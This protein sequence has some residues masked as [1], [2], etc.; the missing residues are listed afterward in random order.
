MRRVRVH[1]DEDEDEDE[2]QD[3]D[4]D[5]DREASPDLVPLHGSRTLSR[6]A[7]KRHLAKDE[8]GG[9]ACGYG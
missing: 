4:Q 3:E 9:E 2:D 5:E 8:S 7:R 1:E 6:P